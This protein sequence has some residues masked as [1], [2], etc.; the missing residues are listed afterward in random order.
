MILRQR[1]DSWMNFALVF[2]KV[3]SDPEVHSRLA[4][5]SRDFTALAG[6]FNATTTE[7]RQTS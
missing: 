2:V 7:I 5:Q 6:V 3:V 1:T 4:L